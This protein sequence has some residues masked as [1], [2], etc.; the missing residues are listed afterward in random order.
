MKILIFTQGR[1]GSTSLATYIGKSLELD[2]IYEPTHPNKN[3]LIDINKLWTRENILI[4]I[5][6]WELHNLNLSFE[7]LSSKFD[8]TIILT[9]EN[10][11]EQAESFYNSFKNNI[12]AE[13]WKIEDIKNFNSEELTQIKN[14]LEIKKN[15]LLKLKGEQFTYESIFITGNDVERLN[16]YLNITNTNFLNFLNKN[17]KLRYK[18]ESNKL[19]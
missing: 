19:I 6:D 10:I 13:N 3:G 16:K 15:D 8:K 17:N 7:E 5:M 12:W 14:S 18:K 9:R 1:S 11:I 2:I 4:K